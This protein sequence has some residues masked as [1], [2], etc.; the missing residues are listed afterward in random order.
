MKTHLA[1]TYTTY[2][3]ERTRS[4]CGRSSG[5][6]WNAETI[7]PGQNVGTEQQVTCFY[8]LRLMASNDKH[9]ARKVV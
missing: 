9:A 6:V 7:L 8:C 2:G 4:L 1:V 5:L 3:E